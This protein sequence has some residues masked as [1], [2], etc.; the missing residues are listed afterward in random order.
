MTEEI[1]RGSRG[2]TAR[3]EKLS[4]EQRKAIAK[5]AAQKRWAKKRDDKGSL[6]TESSDAAVASEQAVVVSDAT[7]E[8]PSSEDKSTEE[9][10]C[11]ACLAGQSLE[12]GEG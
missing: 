10:H 6:S 12:E 11:A 3:K 8:S 4:P 1:K 5:L 9:K 7:T 2:G